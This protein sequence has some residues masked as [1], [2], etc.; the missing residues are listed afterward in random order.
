VRNERGLDARFQVCDGVLETSRFGAR[1]GGHLGVINRNEL[2]HFGE[3][4]F[5]FLEEAGHFDDRGQVAVLSSQRGHPLGVLYSFRVGKLP[6]DL[7]GAV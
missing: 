2:V 4:V 5:V 1:F 6:L 3:L 7:T